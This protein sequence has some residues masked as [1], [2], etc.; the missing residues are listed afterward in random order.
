MNEMVDRVVAAVMADAKA[1][2]DGKKMHDPNAPE[3]TD[4]SA[5]GGSVDV[6]RLVRVGI[7]AMR[8]PVTAMLGSPSAQA[9]GE[10]ALSIWKEMIDIVVWD[11]AK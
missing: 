5:S 7:L 2:L 6:E 10:E 1:Q 4:W 3:W 11:Q 8:D 9:Y